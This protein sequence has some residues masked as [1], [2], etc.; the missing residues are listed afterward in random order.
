VACRRTT[1]S[2]STAAVERW[3]RSFLVRFGRLSSVNGDMLRHQLSS[4]HIRHS[5]QQGRKSLG[6]L[7]EGVAVAQQSV[8]HQCHDTS[9]RPMMV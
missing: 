4:G 6:W 7:V 9:H 3:K 5:R 2:P 8:S 1:I